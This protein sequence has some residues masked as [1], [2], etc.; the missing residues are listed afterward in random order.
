MYTFTEN[1]LQEA[2]TIETLIRQ[3]EKTLT[4]LE[5]G[6]LHARHSGKGDVYS[7]CDLS[8]DHFHSLGRNDNPRVQEIKQYHY[9]R[10]QLE[11]LKKNQ[12]TLARFQKAY[13]P[14][15]PP[16]VNAALSPVYRNPALTESREMILRS[17]P[18]E[19]KAV[20]TPA[21]LWKWS[22]EPY[23]SNSRES[24]RTVVAANGIAMKS[25]LEVICSDTMDR[26]G[27]PFRYEMGIQLLDKA[28]GA[29]V[30][31][32][33]DFTI[34]TLTN[35]LIFWEVAGMLDD[36]SYRQRHFDKLVLY[37]DNGILSGRDLIVTTAANDG[38]FDAS[39]VDYLVRSLIPLVRPECRLVTEA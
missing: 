18:S 9:L 5:G 11:R 31:R 3:A 36:A 38:S 23:R 37:Q 6:Y 26:Y 24:K 21:D 20:L 16:S 4:N 14:Y 34:R 10:K 12:K 30:W 2:R 35:R 33:P 22:R 7:E 15:D 27:I 29:Y 1:L 28:A 13:L 25:L 17:L 32:Y 39:A 19:E 8:R